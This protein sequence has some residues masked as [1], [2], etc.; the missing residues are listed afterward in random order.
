MMYVVD[1]NVIQH[2]IG[3]HKKLQYDE[4]RIQNE[5]MLINCWRSIK[6]MS[7]QHHVDHVCTYCIFIFDSTTLCQDNFITIDTS[8]IIRG[9]VIL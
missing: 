3:R 4:T 7:T 2:L 6:P 9:W 8:Y 1:C 5:Y